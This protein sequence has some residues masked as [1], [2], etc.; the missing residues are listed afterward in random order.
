MANEAYYVSA[1]NRR[2]RTPM[3]STVVYGMALDY[4]N[5]PQWLWLIVGVLLSLYWIA[6]LFEGFA[7]KANIIEF[8]KE[9]GWKI[10]E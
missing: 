6:Y 9:H 5:A 4:Y 3:L 2:I 1:K 10:R 7:V 8:T